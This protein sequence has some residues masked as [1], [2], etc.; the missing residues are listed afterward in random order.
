MLL[1]KTRVGPSAIHGTG[2]FADQL[3][4]K[5]TIIWRFTPGID[6]R[7]APEQVAGL[8]PAARDYLAVYS[9]PSQRPGLRVLCMGNANYFNHSNAPS[10][11]SA[12]E[13]GEEEVVTRALRDIA[14]GEEITDDYRSFDSELQ[15]GW[16][17]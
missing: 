17:R 7:Y 15:E 2:L 6:A 16:V 5:G 13:D 4:E 10:A 1:V 11:L 3:I 14:P 9:F 8:P 12:R